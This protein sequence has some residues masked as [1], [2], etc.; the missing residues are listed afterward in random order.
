ML[1]EERE[2]AQ[3]HVER[4]VVP[5]ARDAL[6][7][8]EEDGVLSTGHRFT[9]QMITTLR[10]GYCNE[11]LNSL[12]DLQH[13]LGNIRQHAVYACCR[14]F[15]RLEQDYDRHAAAMTRRRHRMHEHR[16]ILR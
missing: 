10:C 15:F 12:A 8:M 6:N 13:H 9:T 7:W 16:L 14:R 3:P 1:L 5:V 4:E 11:N 2:R